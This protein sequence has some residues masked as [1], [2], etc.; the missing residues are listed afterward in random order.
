MCVCFFPLPFYKKKGFTPLS[1]QKG[2]HPFPLCETLTS[3]SPFTPATLCASPSRRVRWQVE[4]P[5]GLRMQKHTFLSLS[6][7]LS[8]SLS[9]EADLNPTPLTQHPGA[10][11]IRPRGMYCWCTLHGVATYSSL[12]YTSMSERGKKS[13]RSKSSKREKG[14]KEGKKSS[15]TRLRV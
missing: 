11:A 3:S 13:E 4:V 6:L 7:S 14:R 1:L 2:F 12:L 15:D 9:Q 5:S 10:Q 8:F